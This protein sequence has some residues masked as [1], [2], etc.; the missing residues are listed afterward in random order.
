MKIDKLTSKELASYFDHSILQPNKL[1]QDYLKHI[2]DCKKY[3]FYSAAI[4]SSMTAFY[5]E[6]FKWT[7][8][9]VGVATGFPFGQASIGSK[10]AETREAILIGAHEIDYVLNIGRLLDG[11]HDYIEKEM[12]LIVDCCKEHGVV[13]KVILE[14]CYLGEKEKVKACEIALKTQI[15]F[16]KTSTGFGTGG[17]TYEDVKLMRSVVGNK[18]KI[19]A[20]GAMKTLA[21]VAVMIE[22]G[23]E[24][25][26]SA[27]S[28]CI[29]ED[30]IELKSQG[31]K[32]TDKYE[33]LK[34]M[35]KDT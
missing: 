27:F 26:G 31:L 22:A 1:R 5:V 32:V 30:F 19:K 4:N 7:D 17:A 10:V 21:D 35:E 34:V 3:G 11:E 29:M 28:A 15:D 8:I 16:V 2:E 20:A 14:N 12:Q 25:I 6:T 9:L 13:S 33:N 24:R 18:I 23:V